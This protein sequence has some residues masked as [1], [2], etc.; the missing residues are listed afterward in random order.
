MSSN[1]TIS[2]DNDPKSPLIIVSLPNIIKLNSTN[3]LSWKLQVEATL[4]GYGL[5][6]FLDGSFPSPTPTVTTE[7][8]TQPNPEYLTWMR[9]DRLL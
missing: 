2:N 1:N 9:Q 4:F 8:K 3:Y 7:S 6:K 5:F